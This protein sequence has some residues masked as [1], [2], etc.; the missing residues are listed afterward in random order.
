M[1]VISHPYRG[2][3]TL[4]ALWLS[5]SPSLL[6]DPFLKKYPDQEGQNENQ[7]T[8]NFN[9]RIS[10]SAVSVLRWLN[11]AKLKS[12]PRARRRYKG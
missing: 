5:Q 4:K 2:K 6:V 10:V 9:D 3:K 12:K 11:R 7:L 1:G 8:F